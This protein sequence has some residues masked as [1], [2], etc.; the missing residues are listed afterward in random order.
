MQNLSAYTIDFVII[1]I[2]LAIIISYGVYQGQKV[3]TSAEFFVADKRMPWWA[4]AIAFTTLVLSTQDI[5][6]YSETGY[7]VGFTAFNPY[8]S[9][10]GFVYLFI[11]L[12]A[13]I[14]YFTGVYTV[15]EYL[16]NRYN[17]GTSIA[18]SVA[19]LIF[20]LAIMSFNTYAFA[21]LI[22]GLVGFPVLLTILVLTILISIYTSIGGVVSV[23]T[24]DVL[25][26]VFLIIGGLLVV[27]IGVHAIGGW[28]ELVA[29]TPQQ[30][31]MY[32]TSIND[33]R[34]PA[35][36]MWMGI[37]III[38]A[39]Y[40]MHQGVLQKCLAARSMNGSRLTM[41]VYGLVLLPAGCLFTG[42]PGV[43]T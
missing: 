32:T 4:T 23:I 35:V 27:F 25:Q 11:A 5:V 20:L 6:S 31:M 15:P 30:N 19:I 9:I 8:I 16:K 14:Y 33:P 26:A 36:G 7:I 2:Y 37:S 29:W 34:Y 42:T 10:T 18:G 21:V 13:P 38:A 12:G 22:E 24:V 41:L 39:F 3:K 17:E 43:I 28:G 40:M 1:G